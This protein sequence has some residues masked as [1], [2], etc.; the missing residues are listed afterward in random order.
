MNCDGQV[1][2]GDVGPF[3]MALSSPGNYAVTYPGCPILNGDISGD[4]LFDFCDINPFI[5]LLSELTP[6]Q[7]E[8][9]TVQTG[10][11]TPV[12]IKLS[13]TDACG[14]PLTYII[15]S[16]PTHGTLTDD[17]TQSVIVAGQLPYELESGGQN[18]T[19]S[20]DAEYSGSD[21]FTFRA[22][23]GQ[24][25]SE[26]ATVS[27][28][29]TPVNDPPVASAQSV[30]VDE[31][32][33]KTITLS[34]SDPDG[35][36]LTYVVV[37]LPAHGT[38]RD[39]A[40]NQII[41]PDQ[42]PYTL[43]SGGRKVK[44]LND[45]AY[46]CGPD[47]FTF[48]VHDGQV[49]SPAAAVSITVVYGNHPPVADPQDVPVQQDTPA[50]ITLTAT[51][52]HGDPL[53]FS[54]DVL[55]AHGSLSGTPPNVTYQPVEGYLG[56]DSFVFC[57]SDGCGTS[58]PATVSIVVGSGGWVTPLGIPAPPFGVNEAHTMYA[59]QQWDYGSGPE[60]YRDAGNGPYTHYIDNTHPQATDT[61][62]PFGS[63]TKPRKTIPQNLPAGSVVEVHGGP[64][65]FATGGRTQLGG[66]G[67]AGQPIFI[68]GV[69][70][71]SRPVFQKESEVLGTYVIVEYLDFST[72]D[73]VYVNGPNHHICVRHSIKRDG[74]GRY[75]SA[76]GVGGDSGSSGHDV[77]FYDNQVHDNGDWEAPPSEGDQ[78]YHGLH[79]SQYAYN[80][81]CVD[82]Q[83]WHN[84]GDGIQINAGDGYASTIHHV[85]VA[86]NTA[87][88]NRQTG[89]WCKQA[90]DV[91]FSQNV[92]YHHLNAD[93]SAAGMGWQ[94]E[95]TNLW[96]IFNECYGNL[97][98][99][100]GGSGDG[101]TYIIGNVIHDN[102]DTA[103]NAWNNNLVYVVNN[104]V[105]NTGRGISVETSDALYA[106]NNIVAKMTYS[107]Y[108]HLYIFG[109][110]MQDV[111]HARNNLFYQTGGQVRIEWD[112]SPMNVATFEAVYGAPGRVEDNLEGNPLFVN[113]AGGDFH[114]QTGSPGIDHGTATGVVEEVN[115]TFLDLYGVSIAVDFT[116]AAR[117]AGGAYDMG[118]FE[119]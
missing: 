97:D 100:R 53:T 54:V 37:S 66:S 59:G 80:I 99:I 81:W 68:R 92:A 32:V 86:R 28:T 34:G 39:R 13:A 36:A 79:V 20:P 63:P 87:W 29:V 7:A 75:N 65:T 103:I 46:V 51:D 69:G 62:N 10:E 12:D 26:P 88:E 4:G 76:L 94:Y 112:S 17:A 70:A 119:R 2:F 43:L 16:L 30:D 9:Q 18:V 50:A 11:D 74:V 6:P 109:G 71:D 35:D 19:Y 67:T 38:L 3:V 113:P 107:D 8:S 106:A 108:S 102:T 82:N 85:Y 73:S 84:S 111:S 116:G 95:H 64:Y 56:S 115:S 22:S 72:A 90:T 31:D 52:P 60:A 93:S 42:L 101:K 77:V 89:F 21:S 15:V 114:L 117:P 78:D 96:F 33:T 5:A 104:T 98:G 110:N 25:D 83:M 24:Q 41:T 49:D 47:S 58:S 14:R 48:C 40:T 118:A 1:D 61:N 105:Y 57:A 27:I 44:Y 91:I 55:P 45:L 23:N